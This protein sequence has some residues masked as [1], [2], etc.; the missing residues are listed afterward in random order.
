[1]T[2]HQPISNVIF[3]LPRLTWWL[4]VAA[5]FLVP[6]IRWEG[7]FFPS[8]FP[9]TILF[10]SV[11]ELAVILWIPLAI[12]DKRYR[13]TFSPLVIAVTVFFGVMFFT[14][15]FGVDFYQSLWSNYERMMGLW[16]YAHLFLFFLMLVTVLR[17]ERDWHRLFNVALLSAVLVSLYGIF[18][19]FKL[20]AG[21]PNKIESTFGNSLFLAS[22]LLFFAFIALWFLLKDSRF[23]WRSIAYGVSASVIVAAM[24]F[25]ASRGP[26]LALL[27]GV[28]FFVFCFCKERRKD[29]FCSKYIFKKAIG[30][31]SSSYGSWRVVVLCNA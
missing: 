27:I 9:K 26:M 29:N 16:T 3:W 8:V 11:I 14:A 5:V 7:V 13:P 22:Y 6:I 30:R 17:E 24:L 18:E 1:M 4:L 10:R 23:G 12:F 15:L 20:V 19:H 31:I 25:S 21:T 2:H 28:A